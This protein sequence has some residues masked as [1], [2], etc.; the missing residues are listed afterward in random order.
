M[1]LFCQAAYVKKG[2]FA[3]NNHFHSAS[4]FNKIEMQS[5]GLL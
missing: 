3:A 1:D 2:F 4:E 5:V